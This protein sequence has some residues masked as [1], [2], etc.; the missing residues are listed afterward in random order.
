MGENRSVGCLDFG[1]GT[2]DVEVQADVTL[3]RF[4]VSLSLIAF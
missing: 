2:P 4:A 1:W 3:Q